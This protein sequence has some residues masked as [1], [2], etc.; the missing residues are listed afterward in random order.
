[1]AIS[2]LFRDSEGQDW[3]AP[4]DITTRLLPDLTWSYRV[5]LKPVKMKER[6]LNTAIAVLSI[7]QLLSQPTQSNNLAN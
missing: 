7:T 3:T 2:L 4:W 5:V 1:M 6:A